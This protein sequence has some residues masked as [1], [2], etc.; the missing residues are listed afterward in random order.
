MTV[1]G[2]SGLL[3]AS[4]SEVALGRPPAPAAV[5]PNRAAA[6]LARLPLGFESTDSPGR[7]QARALDYSVALDGGDAVVLLPARPGA[8][9]A[10]L[11]I[12]LPGRH[13]KPVAHSRDP[14][15]ATTNYF[16][17]NDPARWR[18]GVTLFG[19]VAYEGVWPGIDAAWH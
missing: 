14:Q 13:P 8:P 9:R 17:G 11:R 3:G 16:V 19:T 10:T 7:F 2:T 1:L 15:V 5:G 12:S 18:T 4:A 6:M